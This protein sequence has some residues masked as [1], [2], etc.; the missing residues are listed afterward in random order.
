MCKGTGKKAPV[1]SCWKNS[2]HE[3]IED[4][5]G[6]QSPDPEIPLSQV[7]KSKFYLE[8]EGEAYGEIVC[9]QNDQI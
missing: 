9:V 7:K 5:L 4:E 6:F 2:R 8:C 3:G 1:Q